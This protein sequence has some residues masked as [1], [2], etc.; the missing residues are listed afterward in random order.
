MTSEQVA[1][2]PVAEAQPPA[3]APARGRGLSQR[4]FLLIG[5]VII[6]NIVALILVPPFP[7]GRRA[8][9]PVRLPRVLHPGHP[10]VPGAAHRLPLRPSRRPAPASS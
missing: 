2:E 4:W 10:R 8:G 1:T 3:P 7:Q 9:R 5:G 6:L